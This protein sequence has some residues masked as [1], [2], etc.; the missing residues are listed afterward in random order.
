MEPFTMRKRRWFWAWQDHKQEAWFESMSRK[1][2]HLKEVDFITY[3]FERGDPAE[4]VY[5]LDYRPDKDDLD[6]QQFVQEAGWQ[7]IGKTTGWLYFRLPAQAG[8]PAELYTDPEGKIARYKRL[9][10]VT[11][12]TSPV[13]MVVFLSQLKKMPLPLAVL[14]VTVFVAAMIFYAVSL[15]KLNGRIKQLQRT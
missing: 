10:G 6:F 8:Q 15:I 1:G 3:T 2:W 12:A 5:R 9:L 11:A 14:Y 13:Y 4:Y 7:Y